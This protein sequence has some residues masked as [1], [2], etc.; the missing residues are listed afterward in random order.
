M[1][2]YNKY[3]YNKKTNKEKEKLEELNWG[4]WIA[5]IGAGYI[6]YKML[7]KK[8]QAEI[9]RVIGVLKMLMERQ[10]INKIKKKYKVETEYVKLVKKIAIEEK[11]LV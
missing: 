10:P 6:T 2:D 9:Y 1:N 5:T 7:S 3:I 11:I 4:K 8:D